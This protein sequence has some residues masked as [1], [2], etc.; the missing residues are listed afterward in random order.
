MTIQNK[1]LKFEKYLKR[2]KLNPSY[3][4]SNVLFRF[5]EIFMEEMKGT[6]TGDKFRKKIGVEK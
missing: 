2:K 6:E 4:K 1:L 3:E 5:H